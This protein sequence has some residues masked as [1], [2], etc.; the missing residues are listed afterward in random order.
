MDRK[1]FRPSLKL[2]TLLYLLLF[3]II[4]TAI[5]LP[6][7]LNKAGQAITPAA[8][9][10]FPTVT[11][12]DLFFNLDL[13]HQLFQSRQII[14]LVNSNAVR[15]ELTFLIHPDLIIDKLGFTGAQ[16]S[17]LALTGWSFG[18]P[19]SYTRL[20]GTMTLNTVIVQ[21]TNAI[22]PRQMLTMQLDYHLKPGSFQNGLGTNFYGLFVS[23]QN[24][25]AIGFDSGAFP[26]IE[27]NGAAPLRISITYPDSELCGVPGQLVSS[28]NSPGFITSTYQ[29]ARPYD[30]AFSCAAYKKEH[31]SLN[32]IEVE[33]YLTAGQTYRPAM[34]AAALD[35]FRLYRQ[36]FGD[37]GLS[38]FRF[39]YIPTEL[40]GGG[41]ESKGNTVYLGKQNHVDPFS[42]FDTDTNVKNKFIALVGHEE[43]HEW[44]AYYSSWSGDLAQ[45]WTEGGANFMSAWAGEMLWGEAYG[46]ALRAQ[47]S[48]NYN[49][50]MPYLFPGTLESPGNIL[51]GDTWKGE[52]TLT[53]DY[54][55]L[56]WEQL[57]HRI[58]DDALK[59][60]LGD[61][62]QLSS[63][64]PGSYVDFVRCLKS[65]TNVDVAAYLEQW[66]THNA[67]I[68]LSIKQVTVQPDG[69]RFSAVVVISLTGDKDYELFTDL[70]YKTV[71]S[72]D[73]VTI[74]LS[75]SGRGDYSV[76]FTSQER[77]IL[78]QVDPNYLVP[79][80]LYNNDMWPP[81]GPNNP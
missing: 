22:A 34:G 71:N 45:W 53:Y 51:Q 81:S 40:E 50:Q 66:T 6:S 75:F 62:I 60:G 68:D 25:R 12:Y 32:G 35:Y 43:F 76:R 55:A 38:I 1:K 8:Q 20:S 13:T 77:P 69:G 29:A 56:V 26:V 74:P 48:A 70:G 49:T 37:P 28:V 17:P 33:F 5:G 4:A 54:G 59:A 65:H 16:G 36:L 21:F 44:N 42:N 39:V 30:P 24:Q 41:A 52:S 73:W 46:R 58:G 67:R 27:S 2:D 72:S 11:A 23:A 64:Q 61:F 19:V 79:Q 57:R 31:S 14:S 63:R 80:I 3:V 9:G 18:Q 78:L 10:N 7:Y 15:G 47:Y